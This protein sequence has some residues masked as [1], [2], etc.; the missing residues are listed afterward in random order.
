MTNLVQAARKYLGTRWRHRGRNKH[1]VDCAGLVMLS[2]ADCG[3]ELPDYTLY[4]REPHRDGLVQYVIK[5]LGQPLADHDRTLAEGDVLLMRFD[6][7]PHHVA[8]VALADYGGTKAFNIIH[9]DGNVG[10]VIEQRLAPDMAA[11]I[12]HVFRRA[13]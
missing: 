7:E 4:G 5:A 1:A 2:Y 11:R 6:T 3:V 12:T 8:I 9:A 13:V 10:S